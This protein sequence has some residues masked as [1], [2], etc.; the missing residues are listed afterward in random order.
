MKTSPI[1]IGTMRLGK[2]GVGF[3]TAEYEQFIDQCI[4]LGLKDFD[5]ADIYGS[6]TTEEE[7]GAVLKKRKNLRSKLRITT[8]CGIRML[9]PNRPNH[10]IKSYDSRPKHIIQSVDNS[11]KNLHTDYIDL[12][13]LH[14]PDFLMN[15]ADIA[16]T[17]TRLKS[18]GKI[19]HFG[20]SNF[21][22]N[23]VELLN[24]FI[25]VEN[26][27]FQ[28][29]LDHLEPL[30]QGIIDQCTQ[31]KILPSAWSPISGGQLF[32]N[33]TTLKKDRILVAA[34]VLLEKYNC[35]LDQLLISWIIKHPADINPILGTTKILRLA[36]AL[37]SSKVKL[38]HED[39]YLLYQ[40]ST[41]VEIP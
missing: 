15:P 34:R 3:S 40:A 16:E 29:S 10:G 21:S 24:S 19:K 7:F 28:F 11:L 2:W 32:S 41:G 17:I 14:R 37:E 5:H 26:H 12:L 38:S 8:K 9:S 22:T 4:E 13:L 25:P 18:S 31:H 20:V 6:Y 1:I 23:Q 30:N 33:E 35:S 36:S 39:W 27:Q